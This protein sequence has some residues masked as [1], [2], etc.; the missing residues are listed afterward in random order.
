MPNVGDSF[1]LDLDKLFE[2]HGGDREIPSLSYVN[3]KYW[4]YLGDDWDGAFCLYTFNELVSQ[5]DAFDTAVNDTI[6]DRQLFPSYFA[7]AIADVIAIDGSVCV[8]R[9]RTS[10]GTIYT[11]NGQYIPDFMLTEDEIA[12]CCELIR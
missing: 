7:D 3:S 5:S 1:S 8:L 9:M 4:R 12:T 6:E 11:E 10:D 2:Y